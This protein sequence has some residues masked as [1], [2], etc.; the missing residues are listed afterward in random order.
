MREIKF[1]AWDKEDEVMRDRSD[2]GGLHISVIGLLKHL[3]FMQ[4][5]GL[6]DK[7]GV[8]IYSGDILE[9]G[10][11][12]MGRPNIGRVQWGEYAAGWEAHWIN[13]DVGILYRHLSKEDENDYKVIGNIYEDKQLLNTK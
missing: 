3:V 2:V 13:G 11:R 1:R 12:S 5:T 9:Y 4:F 6:K 10:A 7:N 8:E